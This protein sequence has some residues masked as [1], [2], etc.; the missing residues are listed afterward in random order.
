MTRAKTLIGAVLSGVLACDG[1]I[2]APSDRF[3][4]EPLPEEETNSE[5]EPEPTP[6]RPPAYDPPPPD[7]VA[8]PGVLP[9]FGCESHATIK[10]SRRNL[11]DGVRFI[12]YDGDS[13][14]VAYSLVDR[15]GNGIPEQVQIMRYD[16]HGRIVDHVY[17][18]RNPKR[19]TYVYDAAGRVIRQGEDIDGDGEFNFLYDMTYDDAGRVLTRSWT[20][21]SAPG[22]RRDFETYT[23]DSSGALLSYTLDRTGDGAFEERHTY[24]VDEQGRH[25]SKTVDVG[26]DGVANSIT[27]YVWEHPTLEHG[28]ILLDEDGDGEVDVLTYVERDEE[29]RELVR[30]LDNEA[31]GEFDELY[32]ATYDGEGRLVETTTTYYHF[33]SRAEYNLWRETWTYDDRG[34]ELFH[35]RRVYFVDFL[36]TDIRTEST[37]EGSCP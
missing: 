23:Y 12:G 13:A 37:L 33:R 34:R 24:T 16:D 5:P 7:P 32:E 1:S 2:G 29:G 3:V 18:G 20:R 25:L 9:S 31:D 30:N 22:E 6:E 21:D 35:N 11:Y 28:T 26:D 10:E 4:Y 14:R 36:T 17:L 27:T 8:M 19:S 15:D